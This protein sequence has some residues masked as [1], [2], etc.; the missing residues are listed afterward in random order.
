MLTILPRLGEMV[1]IFME[2]TPILIKIRVKIDL[3]SS[4]ATR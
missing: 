3:W 4:Q 1:T 2:T